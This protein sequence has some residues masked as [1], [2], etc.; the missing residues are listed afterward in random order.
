MLELLKFL[1]E[2]LDFLSIAE[3]V[4]KRGNRRAAARL[5][6]ILV[7][8]Y[9]ILE[10]YSILLEEL[11][12]AL[13][14]HEVVC[15]RHR[16]HLNPR[17]VSSLLARQSSNLAVMETL[18]HDLL[19]E[20]RMIDNE[21]AEAYRRLMPGKFGILFDAEW[22]L[23]SGRLP[24]AETEPSAFPASADGA[25]RTLWFTPDPPKEDRRELEKYLYGWNGREKTVLDVNIHDGDAFF[26]AVREYFRTEDPEGRLKD[27]KKVTE[28]YREVLLSTFTTQDLLADISKVRRHYGMLP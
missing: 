20:L 5:H 8:S 9:E 19:D 6:L 10:L 13:E 15:E 4:R 11:Q 1:L 17:H 14:S 26:E 25:Y 21:F 18:T 22:L 24:L 27:L 28:D 7:Q 2:K 12:A 3:A 23:A 16:F